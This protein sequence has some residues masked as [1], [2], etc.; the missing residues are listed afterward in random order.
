[1]SVSFGFSQGDIYPTETQYGG[2]IGFS[3]MYMVL[4]SV[5]GQ[6]FLDT[7]GFNV[8]ELGTRPL[9]F[10]GGE[11]FAQMT[12]PWRLGG[13]AGIGA[14]QASNVYNIHL[15]ANKNNK[16]GYQKENPETDKLYDLDKKLSVKARLNFLLGAMMIE[17]VFPVYRDLEV[18]GGA[19]MGMGRYSFSIDQHIGMPKWSE[20]GRNMFGY[21]KGDSV[22]VELDTWDGKLDNDDDIVEELRKG[23]L[24]P[25]NVNGT[26]TELS[27]TFFNFQPYVAVKWQFLD[28][29]GLRISA[30][31]NKGTI[32]AGKWKLNGQLPVNDSPE[33][34]LGGFTIRTV[35]YFGL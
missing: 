25:I 26:M 19:L 34:A 16:A 9:V 12:G 32:G 15:Y 18:M 1:M 8:N 35:I 33:S 5:P 3:T 2:G 28:R 20:L 31:Y 10:Y 23:G 24:R 29:M 4:D 21:I 30:G 22:M 6:A 11:G 7:L 13:Y 14:T 17:Y 27:G